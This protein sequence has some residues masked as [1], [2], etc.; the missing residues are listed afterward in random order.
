MGTSLKE[1]SK[2]FDVSEAELKILMST[3]P[4]VFNAYTYIENGETVLDNKAVDELEKLYSEEKDKTYV[5]F[6]NI[7]DILDVPVEVIA[8]VIAVNRNK[9]FKGCLKKSPNGEMKFNSFKCKMLT[10]LINEIKDENSISLS[11]LKESNL[12]TETK[13][14]KVTETPTETKTEV[15]VKSDTKSEEKTQ[16]EKKRVPRKKKSKYAVTA[17]VLNN[18]NA[19]IN[20]IKSIRLFL[21]SLPDYKS[22]DI[23]V[24]SD[25]DVRDVFNKTYSSISISNGT[26]IVNKD[27]LK[28]LFTSTDTYFI[29]NS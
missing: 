12:S 3:K 2:S 13:Q 19:E 1:F 6:E 26:L 5:T 14:P 15:D 17:D 7:S 10:Q 22:E 21:L 4:D 18:L 28:T 29:E 25:D 24:M 27:V 20:D 23:A 8:N 11:Q 9:Q 16:D